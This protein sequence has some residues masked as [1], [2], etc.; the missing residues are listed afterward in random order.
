MQIEDTAQNNRLPSKFGCLWRHRHDQE[1]RKTQSVP[2]CFMAA[3]EAFLPARRV[4]SSQ[5]EGLPPA[6]CEE[7]KLAECETVPAKQDACAALQAAAL[8]LV[9]FATPPRSAVLCNSA[10]L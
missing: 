7:L 5:G 3:I 1:Q 8:S 6:E 10:T 9:R 4:D 2:R